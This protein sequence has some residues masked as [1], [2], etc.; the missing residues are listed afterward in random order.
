MLAGAR[1]TE[2]TDW[3]AAGA[4]RGPFGYPGPYDRSCGI[5]KPKRDKDR[6]HVA[7]R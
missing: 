2:P 6:N 5:G 1:L 7:V 3:P 4:F